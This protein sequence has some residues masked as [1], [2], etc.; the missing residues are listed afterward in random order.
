MA[1]NE[2]LEAR[3]AMLEARV[4]AITRPSNAQLAVTVQELVDS[5]NLFKNEQIRVFTSSN[6]TVEVTGSDGIAVSIPSWNSV[7]AAAGY[8]LNVFERSAQTAGASLFRIWPNQKL[9]APTA[10]QGW[11]FS[12][13]A[14]ENAVLRLV[15]ITKGSA[16]RTIVGTITITN[17]VGTYNLTDH[18]LDFNDGLAL[19]V[20]AGSVSALMATLRYL[21]LV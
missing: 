3:V 9:A 15:K 10:A 2:E 13:N 14:G 11:D 7:R 1:T 20:Q 19:E 5:V 16:T 18:E 6:A 12:S 4:N 21:Y 8:D 17:G